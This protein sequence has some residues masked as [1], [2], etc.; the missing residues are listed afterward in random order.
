MTDQFNKIEKES[1]KND[2]GKKEIEK[3]N[4]STNA[5]K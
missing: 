1:L 5:E 4:L 2:M 3:E